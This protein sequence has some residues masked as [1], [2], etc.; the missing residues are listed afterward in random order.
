MSVRQ[1][2]VA[3]E[4]FAL[5]ILVCMTSVVAAQSSAKNLVGTWELNVIDSKQARTIKLF[6]DKGQLRGTYIDGDGKQ[7][8]L[9]RMKSDILRGKRWRLLIQRQ[10]GAIE[11]CT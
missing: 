8:S 6:L 2:S 1:R 11:R 5:V 3:C 4:I 7:L 9:D 10:R